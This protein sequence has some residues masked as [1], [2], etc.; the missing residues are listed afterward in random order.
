[1]NLELKIEV[2]LENF[3][4][5]LHAVIQEEQLKDDFENMLIENGRLVDLIRLKREQTKRL[6]K[7]VDVLKKLRVEYLLKVRQK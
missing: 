6:N 5:V 1:M 4:R 3:D 7:A 2:L